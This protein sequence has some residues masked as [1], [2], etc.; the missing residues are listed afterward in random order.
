MGLRSGRSTRL[1]IP[2]RSGLIPSML[3]PRSI[4]VLS[5]F[6]QQ[7]WNGGTSAGRADAPRNK[8]EE[9]IVATEF[10]P[11][12]RSDAPM[13]PL[14]VLPARRTTPDQSREPARE[15]GKKLEAAGGYSV[16]SITAAI[17]ARGVGSAPIP[18]SQVHSD[19]EKCRRERAGRWRSFPSWQKSPRNSRRVHSIRFP[20]F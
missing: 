13:P 7:R 14:F 3:K 5:S 16:S 17:G 9:I 6:G 8:R 15:S 18:L 4:T 19:C 10:R 1:L 20:R 11:L 12:C 2:G